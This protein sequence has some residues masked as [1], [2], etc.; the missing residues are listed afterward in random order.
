[1][2]ILSKTFVKPTRMAYLKI[3]KIFNLVD[4]LELTKSNISSLLTGFALY[5]IPVKF[6][7]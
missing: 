4:I 3:I 2:G 5:Q 1:M 7:V 6:K